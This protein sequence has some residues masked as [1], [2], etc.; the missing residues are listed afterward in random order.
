V[1][2]VLVS[3]RVTIIVSAIEG[4]ATIRAIQAAYI[5]LER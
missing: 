5:R 2:A 4:A 3:G 1:W